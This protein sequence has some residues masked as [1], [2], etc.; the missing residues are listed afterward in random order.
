LEIGILNPGSYRIWVAGFD[1]KTHTQT[2]PDFPAH[3]FLV[4]VVI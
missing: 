2:H 1:L 3:L 4:P